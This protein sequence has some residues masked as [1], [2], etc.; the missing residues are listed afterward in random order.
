VPIFTVIPRNGGTV[1]DQWFSGG[2]GHALWFDIL[3]G[4]QYCNQDIL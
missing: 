3:L 1:G 4:S 2:V